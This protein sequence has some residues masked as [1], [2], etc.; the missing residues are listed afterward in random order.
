MSEF[1]AQDEH[2]A[3]RVRESFS[4]QGVMGYLG[5]V[6]GDVTPGACDI[7][8]PYHEGLSQQHGFFHGGIVGT[9]ADSAAGYAGYS[10][11]P[12]E[13]SVL[14]VE[15]K[16]NLLAPADGELLIARGAVVKAGRNLV[17]AKAD[18]AVLKAGREK[19]CATLLQTLMTVH[20][21]PDVSP[22]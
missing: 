20:N 13:A 16:L 17:I 22:G 7:R 6:L 18:V 3:Q 10:L 1:T 8:L 11:M 15:Y 12:A 2:F 4:R 21:R 5:A 9:I 19:P 14:T